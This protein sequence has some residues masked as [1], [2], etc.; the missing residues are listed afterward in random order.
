MLNH[1]RPL[2][3]PKWQ[4]G[5][6]RAAGASFNAEV[7]IFTYDGE[8]VY[9]PETD[10]WAATTTTWYLGPARVQPVRSGRQVN[11]EGNATSIQAVLLS[12]PIAEN[13]VDFRVGMQVHVLDAPLNPSVQVFEFVVQDIVDASNAFERTLFLTVDQE[14]RRGEG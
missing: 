5:V 8:P 6:S 2:Y 13:D 10:T 7:T 3:T 9:D 11:V 4:R 1:V 14:H 12:L